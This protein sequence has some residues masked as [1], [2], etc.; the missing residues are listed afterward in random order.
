MA[1][2]IIQC[3]RKTWTKYIV[4]AEDEDSAIWASDDWEYLGY[5]DDEDTKTML[6]A[7]PFRS[8]EEAMEDTAS[9]VDG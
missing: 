4:E 2:F 1:W 3:E 5:L 8:K 9:Y 6:A 7:G